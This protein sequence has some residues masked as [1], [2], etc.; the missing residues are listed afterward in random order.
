MECTLLAVDYDQCLF[1][2]YSRSHRSFLPS[3]VL[4][5]IGWVISGR[6]LMDGRVLVGEVGGEG[7]DAGRMEEGHHQLHCIIITTVTTG[8][9]DGSML[10][11][12]TYLGVGIFTT[13]TEI[14][15][16]GKETCTL[17]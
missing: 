17:L 2:K 13:T 4:T 7:G 14:H 1:D 8:R 9:E 10:L 6:V 15:S 11:F 16:Q 5:M 12:S 3:A